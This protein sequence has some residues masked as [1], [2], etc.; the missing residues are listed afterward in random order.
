[1]NRFEGLSGAETAAAED[2]AAVRQA[3]R[4][5]ENQARAPTKSNI[6]K[7]SAAIRMT[8]E[9]PIAVLEEAIFVKPGETQNQAIKRFFDENLKGREANIVSSGETA[10]FDQIGKYLYP[11]HKV[12]N[13]SVK[14]T[15]VAILKD[16]VS[17]G[18][19]KRHMDDLLVD[20]HR[21]SHSGLNAEN[22]W[23]YYTT[24]FAVDKSGTI[25]EGTLIIR[26][27][28]NGKDYFY[29]LDNIKKTGRL[30]V[31]KKSNPIN[32]GQSFEQSIYH[33]ASK[34]KDEISE[35]PETERFSR[36]GFSNMNSG[37]SG[38]SMSVRAAEAYDSGEKPMSK[39]S[40]GEILGAA[41]EINPDIVP[42]LKEIRADVLKR[43]LLLRTSWH[44]TSSYANATDFYSINEDRLRSLT[45]DAVK[46]WNIERPVIENEKYRGDIDYIEWTGT[47]KH[48]KANPMRLSDVNIEERGSFYIIT[49]DDGREL[50][51]K[52]KG[53]NGTHVYRSDSGSSRKGNFDRIT[54]GMYVGG[55]PDKITSGMSDDDRYEILRGRTL[56]ISAKADNNKLKRAEAKFGSKT[57]NSH[58]LKLADRKRLFKK[59][60]EE[61]GVFKTYENADVE[62]DFTFSK[63]NMDEST[64]KQS[65][66][67]EDYA[68]LF[69]CFD[70]VI[71]NAI[72][73][74]V[75][76]RN[77][78]GY[79]PDMTLSNVYVLMSVFED[80][81]R[82]VPVKLEIKEF[83]GEKDNTLHVAV[84]L[85]SIKKGEIVNVTKAVNDGQANTSP[86]LN[87]KI[88]DLFRKINPLD[89]DFLKY[90]PKQFFETPVSYSRDSSITSHP[91]QWSAERQLKRTEKPT[92]RAD[93]VARFARERIAALDSDVD[94]KEITRSMQSLGDFIVQ[95]GESGILVYEEVKD[96][97]IDIARALAENA[98]ELINSEQL[99][100][101]LTQIPD[102]NLRSIYDIIIFKGCLCFLF[103][104]G[105]PE[106]NCRGFYIVG[107]FAVIILLNSSEDL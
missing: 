74:E 63:S 95:N 94:A 66:R 82:V 37:Y 99:R 19:D 97:A 50:L 87:V 40:K 60:R 44:H 72:G 38:Y 33:N 101:Y 20:G 64:V 106:R 30:D 48:P 79:K 5:S 55:K 2:M 102:C 46:E 104:C 31:D 6:D 107:Y 84:A 78:Q 53:S 98:S 35:A 89:A 15:A 56:S 26:K 23:D 88:A 43:Y 52:K 36:A 25:W 105:F 69:T 24:R 96:R 13:M 32:M 47:R 49:D 51:R 65:E 42:A 18:T 12:K 54:A 103:G 93:D 68:K 4:Y 85:Q 80:G 22:G 90:I 73:V 61:F 62:L 17:L 71:E 86:S 57:E 21:K 29:D 11:G 76:N 7:M 14:K 41:K 59:L 45:E 9:G 81:N 67:Y 58:E 100:E 16:M 92:L 28:I 83:E 10:Q 75:H 8:E 77:E 34:V 39:W 27:S 1:M 70:D 91:G 3:T